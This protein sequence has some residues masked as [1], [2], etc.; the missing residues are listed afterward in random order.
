MD[1]ESEILNGYGGKCA[2]DLLQV[3]GNDTAS[4]RN[5]STL[6]YSP[7]IT[8]TDLAQ[9]LEGHTDK[10]SVFSINAQSINAKFDDILATITDLK[11]QHFSFSALCIQET[12]LSDHADTSLLQIPGYSLIS[13]GHSCGTHGGLIIY[14]HEKYTFKI[15]NLCNNSDL[16]EGMFIEVNGGGLT[17]KIVLGNMYRPPRYNNNNQTVRDF[18]SEIS[19]ILSNLG[20]KSQTAI[21]VGDFNLDLLQI[22]NRDV[23]Q[24]YLDL[25]LGHSFYPKLTFPT[26]FARKKGTLIDQIYCKLS[27][28]TLKTT[29]G[30]I[31]SQ[32]SDHLPYYTCIDVRKIKTTTKFVKTNTCNESAMERFSNHIRTAMLNTTFENNLHSDPN[33]NYNKLE[34]VITEAKK[35]HLPEKTVKF[36]KHKH[37]RNSWITMGILRSIKY[38]DRLYKDLI[39]STKNTI[40]YETLSTNLRSYNKILRK[41]I[42][43][44]KHKY[45]HSIF[46]TYRSDIRKTWDHINEVLFRTKKP[47]E[48]PAYL[49]IDGSKIEDETE[50]A[51]RFNNFFVNIGPNLSKN[52]NHNSHRTFSSFLKNNITHSFEFKN[53]DINIVHKTIHALNT[54]NS[55]GHDGLST[56]LLKRIAPVITR[57][58]T[59][60]INQ[61]LNTGIFPDKLKIAKVVP[62]YKK[63]D[64]YII[65]NYRPISLL[66]SLS[67][68]FEKIVFKQLYDYFIEKKASM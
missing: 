44:S 3:L 56:K 61:S 5:I 20:N 59:V 50:M 38:R 6:S 14:L 55:T 9:H 39:S 53:I 52:I 11:N 34:T 29:S 28:H 65:D 10:F 12:W 49:K 23:L 45:Y 2:N 57:P 67:K 68:I 26:R 32:I 58:L 25:F 18:L 4:D 30:I 64:C 21:I 16:W 42:R 13:M 36:N 54:K 66:P 24:E 51:T 40:Q 37:K 60:I 7:Y 22:E 19:P 46:E 15:C 27:E 47:N 35:T 8:T 48:L 63:G 31:L 43:Q 62:L 33:D 1:L 17:E 41:C